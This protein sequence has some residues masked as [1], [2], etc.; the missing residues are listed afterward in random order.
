MKLNKRQQKLLEKYKQIMEKSID[1]NDEEVGHMVC[2]G[3]LCDLLHDLG[4]DEV[5]EIYEKQ[6]RWYA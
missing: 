2:D 4:F 6:I 5:L 1:N 3:V